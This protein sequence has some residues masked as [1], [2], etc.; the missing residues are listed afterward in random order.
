MSVLCVNVSAEEAVELT[1]VEKSVVK[2]RNADANGDGTYSTD[3]VRILL[4][5]A[6]GTIEDNAAYDVD[7]NGY[8]SVE[9]ALAVLRETAGVKPLLS[10]AEALELVNTKLNGVKVEK[11]GFDCISTAQC[12]SMKVTQKITAEGSMAGLLNAMLKDMNYTD[13]EYDQYVDKM[14][15]QLESSKNNDELTA[16]DKAEIDR[17]IAAMKKSG[18]TYDDVERVEKTVISGN[19][20]G[21]K[22]YFPR[23]GEAEVASAL[24][25]ADIDD[26]TYMIVNDEIIFDIT[27]ENTAY[28]NASYP[29]TS[30]GL[31]NLPYGKVF[32]LPFLRGESGSTLLKAEYNNG[33]V[34]VILD[35][36]TAAIEKAAYS[37]NYFSNVK[38][39][40]Q[41]NTQEGITLK[42]E[43][44]TKM[45]ATI[46]ETFTF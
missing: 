9:D 19:I 14:V 3:D 13:L 5:A 32:N 12:T 18:E 17:Q 29:K 20:N 39:P 30:D 23:A 22:N 36:D 42:V 35:K 24:T 25:V 2:L 46:S 16:A 26:I 21:H 1:S 8:T 10:D 33:K 28:T 31:A 37:Y 44:A 43:M 41:S 15:A 40:V 7:S 4:R 45:Y 34:Q 11:P 27:M 38:A 6:A